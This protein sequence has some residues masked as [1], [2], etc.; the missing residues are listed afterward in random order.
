MTTS[1]EEPSCARPA[2][3]SPPRA[4]WHLA[5]PLA[6]ESGKMA[7]KKAFMLGGL[8]KGS[9]RATFQ[10]LKEAGFDGVELISPN[11]LDLQEVLKARDETGLV[12]HGV[13][14][15]RHW[16]VPFPTPTQ[17]VV[18]RGMEAIRRE[19]RRL[20]GLRRQHGPGRARGCQS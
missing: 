19:F 4:S 13:S 1:S 15:S 11:D 16:E 7:W 18:A 9:P 10:L 6:N 2:P 17:Q 3:R 12:I 8:N 5:V 14:G 20:Q